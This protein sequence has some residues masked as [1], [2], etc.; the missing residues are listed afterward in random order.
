MGKGMR[1]K[2]KHN[3]N[4][5]WEHYNTEETT[6]C[7]ALYSTLVEHYKLTKGL[8]EYTKLE[9]EMQD[10]HRHGHTIRNGDN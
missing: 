4:S 9:K 1:L 6:V 2:N 7:L 5:G 8:E 3:P 10:G